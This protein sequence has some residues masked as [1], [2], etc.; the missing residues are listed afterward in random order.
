MGRLAGL[1][2]PGIARARELLRVLEGEHLVPALAAGR[3]AA[4]RSGSAERGA[5]A[6]APPEQLTFFVPAPPD[7]V[8]ERLRALDADA[9]TPLQALTL[10]AELAAEARAGGLADAPVVAPPA[11]R[12]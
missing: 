4:P 7:R 6:A 12:A 9:L 3:T 11:A 5:R 2:A 1:P 10:L 8:V